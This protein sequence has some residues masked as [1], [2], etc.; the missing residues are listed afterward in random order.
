M[1]MHAIYTSILNTPCLQAEALGMSPKMKKKLQML[2]HATYRSIEYAMLAS[3][4][5]G[6]SPKM[7]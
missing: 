7:R 3:R 5:F 4:R 1:L 6:M 2:M